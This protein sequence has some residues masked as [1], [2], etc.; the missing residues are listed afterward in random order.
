MV[1]KLNTRKL[2]E[3]IGFV[4]H[5]KQ[6][7]ILQNMQQFTVVV[8]AR[9]L[10]KTLIAAYLVMKELFLPNRSIWIVAPTHDLAS[11]VWEYLD[12]W[13]NDHFQGVFIVNRHEKIIENKM[14]GS[15]VWAKTA[16]SR[17]SLRGKGLDLVILDEAALLPQEVW[18]GNLGPNLMDKGEHA[19]AFFISNPFGFNWF[20]DI[21]LYGTPE[22]QLEPGR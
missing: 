3:V 19:R 4:P 16:E 12:K 21:Y 14:T 2:K 13:V 11:R 6:R 17:N 5:E 8:G 1:E 7:E 9:R 20:Y 10:G 15:K 18:F 22:G